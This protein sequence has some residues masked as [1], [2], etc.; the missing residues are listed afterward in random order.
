MA[1]ESLASPSP[2][3]SIMKVREVQSAM[4]SSIVKENAAQNKEVPP[5][6]NAQSAMQTAMS[7]V[8]V[9]EE[10]LS[11]SNSFSPRDSLS[12]RKVNSPLPLVA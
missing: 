6:R 12:Q 7:Q 10:S 5:S 3:S 4:P 1:S 2:K 8:S 9:K 11:L